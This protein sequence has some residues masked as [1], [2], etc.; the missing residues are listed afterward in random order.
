VDRASLELLLGQGLSLAEIG[1]RFGRHEST[2]AYWVQRHGLE[3]VGR[4]K[5]TL[6]RVRSSASNSRRSSR[7]G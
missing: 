6:Q 2:I 3:A 7:R 4:D 5:H 1:R